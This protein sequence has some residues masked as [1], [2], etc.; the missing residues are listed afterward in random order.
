MKDDDIY[1]QPTSYSSSA[2]RIIALATQV[3]MIFVSSFYTP[4]LLNEEMTRMREIVDQHFL[5]NWIISI[6]Q[7]YLIDLT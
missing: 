2:Y 1:Q 6:Y 7:G 4:N 5:N 3:S